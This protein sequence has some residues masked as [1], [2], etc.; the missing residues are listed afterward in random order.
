[1]LTSR[2]AGPDVQ[3]NCSCD[4]VRAWPLT[5][6]PKPK[7]KAP[8]T[9]VELANFMSKPRGSFYFRRTAVSVIS[10]TLAKAL[11]SGHSCFAAAAI[12]WK[13]A[14]SIPATFASRRK[15]M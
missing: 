11:D 14:S 15:A 8:M 1:M 9:R 13:V 2:L 4:S 10:G 3:R 5:A 12:F 7:H 6:L